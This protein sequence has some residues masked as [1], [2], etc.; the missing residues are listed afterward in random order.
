MRRTRWLFLFAIIFIVVAVGATYLKRKG[1]LEKDAPARPKPLGKNFDGSFDRWTYSDQ[2]GT[3]PHVTISADRMRESAGS[4][5]LDLEGVE[6]KLYTKDGSQYDLVKTDKAKCDPAAKT[7]YADDEVDITMAVPVDGPQHGRIVKIQTSGVKFDTQTGKAN[8][9]RPVRFEFDQGGGTSTGA[10]YDPQTRELHMKSQISLDWRGK[11]A[12][13][14]PMHIESGEAFYKEKESKVILIPWSKLTRDTL[15]LEGKMSVVTLDKGE[16]RLAEIEAGHGTKEDP[17]RK[18][19]FGSDQMTMNFADGMLVTKITGDH[20]AHLIST[21]DVARTTVTGEKMDLGFEATGKESTLSTAVATGKSVAENEPIAKPGT[22]PGDTRILHSEVIHLK[23][24][25]GGQEIESVETDGAGTLDF[26]PN[27]PGLPKRLMTGDKIW[28]KYGEDNRIESFKSVNVTTRT[29]NPPVNGKPVAPSFTSSKEM[30]ALFDPNTS[31]MSHL[32]QKNDF[33]YDAGDRHAR[34]DH[35][36]LDQHTDMMTLEKGARVWDSTG[37][38]AADRIVMN[39][40]SGDFTADGHVASTRM[41]DPKGKSSAML[42][43]DEIMQARAQRMVS[44]DSNAKIHYEGNAVAWQGSNRVEAERLDIDRDD[45]TLAAH[46][47]VVSQ[48]VD[49]DKDKEKDKDGKMVKTKAAKTSTTAPIFTVVH[50]PELFYTDETR[51]AVYKGGV[52]LQRPDLTVTGTEVKAFL[53]AADADSSLNKTVADGAVKILSN[54]TKR[55]KTRTGTSD[56]A[57][58]Y[59]DDGKV[60]LS[61]GRPLL[62]DSKEGKTQGDQ[63]TW[64]ANDDRLLV[65]GTPSSP[66]KSIV[67]KK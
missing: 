2:K 4:T 45:G 39:Q 12:D 32:D 38:A 25:S 19:E 56:H 22:Q 54:D 51:I 34:A 62:I 27:R 50:A 47:K 37:S 11:T 64:W 49:K 3:T 46:G 13:S 30:A 23:M 7:L 20:N 28:I 43:T 9:D 41:P 63:L 53:N 8:T 48:F 55:V 35:A 29:D 24:R 57:E 61:G 16:V 26:L 59:A 40:K 36:T 52:L 44:T 15:R 65:N 60:I 66:V 14:V 42:N 21:T 18:V 17:G 5:A 33:K 10:E 67:H 1:N 31:D 58:Y 6:L